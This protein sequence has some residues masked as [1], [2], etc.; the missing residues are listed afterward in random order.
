MEINYLEQN[1]RRLHKMEKKMVLWKQYNKQIFT[2]SDKKKKKNREKKKENNI[3]SQQEVLITG[4]EELLP[5]Q[6]EYH[7][8][9][10]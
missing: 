4:T 10:K 2:K 3:K 1:T 6:W 7:L 9:P 5:I 8:L